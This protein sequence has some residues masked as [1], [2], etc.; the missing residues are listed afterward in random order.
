LPEILDAYEALCLDWFL[1]ER[2]PGMVAV[3]H[4][5]QRVLHGFALLCLAPESFASWRQA[6]LLRY[7]R[8]VTP[9]LVDRSDS[10]TARFVLLRTLE[11]IAPWRRQPASDRV[12][13]TARLVVGPETPL[14]AGV[15]R[16]ITFVDDECR[17]IGAD[18][19]IGTFDGYP[20]ALQTLRALGLGPERCEQVPNRTLTWLRGEAVD[21]LVFRRCLDYSQPK[22]PNTKS[23]TSSTVLWSSP[24][25]SG[26]TARSVSDGASDT[27]V[28]ARPCSPHTTTV[29]AAVE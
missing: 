9:L 24:A 4:D 13:P 5:D 25:T 19:W 16:L 6:A 12:A 20:S 27:P 3:L 8:R 17:A 15:D 2:S 1:V 21:R 10:E 23:R 28:S 22:G 18:R 14:I 7:L 11:Q 26:S 29:P